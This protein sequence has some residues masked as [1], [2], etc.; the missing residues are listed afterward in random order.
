M[1]TVWRASRQTIKCCLSSHH[2]NAYGCFYV[3][4]QVH[5]YVEFTNVA[6]GA[7]RQTNFAFCNFNARGGQCISDVVGADR[8]E[9]LAFVTIGGSDSHFQLS[10][11]GS[12]SFGRSFFVCCCFF[13]LST[14]LFKRS[15]VGSGCSGGFAVWQQVV[16]TVAGL[17]V[18]FV[19]QVA[20][21][22]DFFQRSEEHTS[23]LQSHH[24]LVCRL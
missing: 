18:H 8:T 13:Q 23:E 9:Q 11:L 22:G 24:D 19:A 12:A 1:L 16:T 3:A 2:N 10:Q 7:V 17:N 14:T 15:Q 20:Q 4:V 5:G 6:D 21:V